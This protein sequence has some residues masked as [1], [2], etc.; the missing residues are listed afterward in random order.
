MLVRSI[1]TTPVLSRELEPLQVADPL[2]QQLCE[3]V[4][5]VLM[6]HY[7]LYD[8]LIEADRRKGFIDI[9]NVSLDGQLGCRIYMGGPATSSELEKLA[10]RYGGEILERFGVTRGA[11]RI[12]EIDALETDFAGRV[13]NVDRS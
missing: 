4:G 5:A 12:Q 7:P 3:I 1:D 13:I 9:R 10:M 11:M 2:D 8:W 6:K